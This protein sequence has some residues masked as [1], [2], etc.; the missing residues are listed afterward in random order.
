[1]GLLGWLRAFWQ[2]DAMPA[3][4]ADTLGAATLPKQPDPLPHVVIDTRGRAVPEECVKLV[5]KW[6]GFREDSYL[7]QAGV[8][9]IG[10]GTTRWPDGRRVKAGEKITRQVADGMMRLQLRDF[11]SEV[12]RLVSVPLAAHERAALISFAYNVG[13]SAFASSTLRR[14]LNEGDRAGAA[15][16]FRRW[17]KANGQVSQGLVNRRVEEAALFRGAA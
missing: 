17:N 3:P 9:T 4:G 7:C 16:Q 10:Y 15:E 2:R 6:E 14:L 13:S 8:W 1:M 5:A 11:A 12:D